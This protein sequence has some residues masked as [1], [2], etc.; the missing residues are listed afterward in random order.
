MAPVNSPRTRS[1]TAMALSSFSGA[2]S[3]QYSSSMP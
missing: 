3:F 1:G 2:I